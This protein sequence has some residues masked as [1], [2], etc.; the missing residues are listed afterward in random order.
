MAA[1]SQR[2]LNGMS[3]SMPHDHDDQTCVGGP[4]YFHGACHIK[5]PTWASY[6]A[7]VVTITC[8]ECR[9]LIARVHVAEEVPR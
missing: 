6:E 5:A 8:C 3:C 9:S 4:L 1:L 7:G 2:E